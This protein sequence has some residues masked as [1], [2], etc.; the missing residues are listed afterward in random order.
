MKLFLKTA[1]GLGVLF[2][3]FVSYAYFGNPPE[4]FPTGSVSAQRL[5]PGPWTVASWSN[6]FVDRRRNTQANG[7]YPGAPERRLPGTVWYPHEA[8][9]GERPLLLFSHGFTSFRANGRYLGEH[10]ASHGFVVVAV[11][12][13]LTSITAPGGA[14]V[15]DVMNQPGDISF[16]IDTLTARSSVA[17]H[18]LS[19]KIDSRRIGVF[20][21]SLGGL[22]S[23]LAGYHPELRD[24]RISAVLSIAG[25]THFFT[26]VF[27][28]HG[29]APF[30]MLAGEF[31]ALVPWAT[32]AQPVPD[33]IPGARLVTVARGAHTGFSFGARWLR[34]LKNPDLVGC[35][36]VTAN[37]EDD[38]APEQW[39][40]MLGPA[41]IGIDYS[42]G[43]ELCRVDP[44]P[45]SLNVLRQ[46]MIA[47]VVIRAFFEGTLARDIE[48]RERASRYLD[49][50][51]AAELA[52]VAVRGAKASL[53]ARS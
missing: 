16:L 3:A 13:P 22:T 52:D 42:V 29:D 9:A 23:T 28:T 33:K 2:A 53:S 37:I 43:D 14:F 48:T 15:D 38:A 41:E 36:F 7:D 19:G 40:G 21:I 45:R 49:E 35:Y 30:L 11:D 27:F 1:L 10:L 4:A 26:P 31:D 44:L 32:N 34:M 18:P 39:A 6:T 5:A 51:L 46:Q 24:P 20:G 25:P 8:E 50:V 47:R 12:Y 17:G